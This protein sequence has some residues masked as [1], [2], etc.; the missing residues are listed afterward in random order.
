MQQI[1]DEGK[2]YITQKHTEANMKR[3]GDEYRYW[4]DVKETEASHRG[5]EEEEY[6]EP[7]NNPK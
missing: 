3:Y 6:E 7:F 4:R 5:D 2:S 1:G